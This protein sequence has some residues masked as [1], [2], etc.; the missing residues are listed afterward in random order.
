MI[1]VGFASPR[2]MAPPIPAHP[3]WR[4]I[5]GSLERYWR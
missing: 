2:D 3:T 1:K 4:N 5:P